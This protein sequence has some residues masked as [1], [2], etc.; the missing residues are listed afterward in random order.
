MG[1]IRELTHQQIRGRSRVGVG[2]GQVDRFLQSPP[3]KVEN[4]GL[5]CNRCK[6]FDGNA[7]R[8]IFHKKVWLDP[9]ESSMITDISANRSEWERKKRVKTHPPFQHPRPFTGH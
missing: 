7:L 9:S 8:P 2:R 1:R 5:L 4:G 6:S 3:P